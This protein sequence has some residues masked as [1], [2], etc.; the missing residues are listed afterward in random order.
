[1]GCGEMAPEA[2]RK[3]LLEGEEGLWEEGGIILAGGSDAKGGLGRG[4]TM[5]CLRSL[6]FILKQQVLF[7]FVF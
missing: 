1:M 6:Y 2:P 4:W 5:N 3:G 7:C